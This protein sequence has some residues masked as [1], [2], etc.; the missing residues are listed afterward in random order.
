[1][2]EGI[3]GNLK[4]GVLSVHTASL[5]FCIYGVPLVFSMCDT[6]L[7]LAAHSTEAKPVFV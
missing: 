4:L 7:F 6:Y 1:M 3:V 5:Y 2:R